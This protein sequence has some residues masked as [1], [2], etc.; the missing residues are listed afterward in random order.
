M[1]CN[2]R[3]SAGALHLVI[4]RVWRAV[5][6]LL[7]VP[8]ARVGTNRVPRLDASVL[9]VQDRGVEG[10]IVGLGTLVLISLALLYA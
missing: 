6:K 1:P 7:D 4:S 9:P 5:R 2:K 10:I 3:D 8:V